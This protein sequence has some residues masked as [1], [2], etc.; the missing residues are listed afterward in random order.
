MEKSLC[1]D[2][3]MLID[4]IPVE[5]KECGYTYYKCPRCGED[6]VTDEYETCRVCHEYVDRLAAAELNGEYYCEK[7]V[8]K[9]AA[10]AMRKIEAMPWEER[11]A[12]NIKYDGV[13]I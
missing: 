8:E 12:L 10:R 4:P 13:Q 3:N 6:N 2:C 7:C 9:N 1:L 5:D 11:A